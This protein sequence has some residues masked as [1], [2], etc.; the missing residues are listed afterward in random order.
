MRT[1]V[2]SWKPC[3]ITVL[4]CFSTV[5]TGFIFICLLLYHC[6]CISSPRAIVCTHLRCQHPIQASEPLRGKER[7]EW[8]LN[9]TDSAE[10]GGA[11]ITFPW[12]F[13]HKGSWVPAWLTTGG[14]GKGPGAS[15]V[16]LICKL[17]F[18]PTF[19]Q[20][21][22]TGPSRLDVNV[23]SLAYKWIHVIL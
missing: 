18:P 5:Y 3:L 14:L 21:H 16:I 19:S 7:K 10:R 9:R 22:Y 6:P 1:K 8:W 20:N 4:L 17:S 12:L 15:Q 2:P 13:H 11:G 23:S